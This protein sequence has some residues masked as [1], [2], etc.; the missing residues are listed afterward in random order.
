M[1]DLVGVSKHDHNFFFPISQGIL[2]L[3]K[4]CLLFVHELSIRVLMNKINKQQKKKKKNCEISCKNESNFKL[5]KLEK[6][7]MAAK[8]KM[9][10]HITSGNE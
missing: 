9:V 7:L 10:Y 5:K 8:L 3:F 6:N 1:A 4:I 2:L